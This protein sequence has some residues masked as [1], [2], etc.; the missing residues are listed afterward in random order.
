MKRTASELKGALLGTL[1]GDAYISNRGEFGCEQIT[2]NLIDYKANILKSIH[3]D[4]KVYYD[5][6]HREATDFNKN[7]KR[8]YRI[9]TNKHPYFLKL[10]E[11]LYRD[12]GK[13]VSSSVLN[14]LTPEG[15]ALWFMDD[16]YCDYKKSNNTKN[17]RICT[18]SYDSFSIEQIQTYF[19]NTWNIP[20]KVMMHKA[21]ANY[22]PK[23]RVSIGGSKP[24]QSFVTLVYKYFLPEFYYKIDL[25]YT[26]QTLKSKR[27]SDDYREAVEYMLQNLSKE[28]IV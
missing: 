14:R 5:T 24:M 11:E 26:D 10:R 17:L 12:T 16:G 25:H 2:K 7:P 3:P 6:R 20:T 27:C 28:D 9:Q 18:D 4:I 8:S 15:I 21:R 1:L 23:P 22:I 13:Q 19:N